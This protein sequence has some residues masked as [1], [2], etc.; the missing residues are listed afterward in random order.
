MVTLLC[1]LFAYMFITTLDSHACIYVTQHAHIH[2]NACTH[3]HTQ[4]H[5]HTQPHIQTHLTI[6]AQTTTCIH[7]RVHLEP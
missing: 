1:Q 5:M 3:T 2:T 7:L 4:T 6:Y